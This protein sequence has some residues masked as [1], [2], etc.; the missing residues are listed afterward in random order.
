MSRRPRF[1]LLN[2][3]G[4]LTLL[5]L[6][7][8]VLAGILLWWIESRDWV[9]TDNAY[10]TG[11]LI[12]LA[13]QTSGTVV[14]VLAENTHEV[15]AGKVLVRL[16]GARARFAWEEAK[17]HLGDTVRRVTARFADAERL[18]HQVE[19]RQAALDRLRHDQARYRRAVEEEA[20]PRQQLQN[21]EDLIRETEALIEQARAELAGVEA[22]L[23]GTTPETHPAVAEA[24]A[25]LRQKFLDYSRRDIVAPVAGHIAKRKVQVGDRV[26]PGAP[27]L[28]IVP[29]D[30]L[31]VEANL[32]EKD[33]ARVR[34][35][36]EAEV[37]VDML[38]GRQPYRGRVEG[39]HPG[40]GSLF[41]LLPPENTSGNFIHISERVPV[42][43]ALSAKELKERPLRQGLSTFTRIHVRD[44]GRPPLQSDVDIRRPGYRTDV[45]E[46]ETRAAD[47]Q[48]RD[49]IRANLSRKPP[50]SARNTP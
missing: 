39:I 9:S 17:A 21:T 19:A 34:P 36:Q 43:I 35:G 37:I 40:T 20:I 11:H 29:L 8:L 27:L 33:L 10:V 4:R 47:R 46:A 23:D 49:I 24:A 44:N 3:L 41:A 2:W 1:R 5:L 26:E 45:F 25:S 13:A 18:R 31:W 50:S 14:E 42:R 16:D 38:G 28:A 22:A 15:K 48:I 7:L 32:K 12:T 6:A 30:Q